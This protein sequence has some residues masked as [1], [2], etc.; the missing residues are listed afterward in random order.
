MLADWN[1]VTNMCMLLSVGM[2][3]SVLRSVSRKV[4]CTRTHMRSTPSVVRETVTSWHQKGD[5]R[6]RWHRCVIRK[7]G[8]HIDHP[9]GADDYVWS[10]LKGEVKKALR[11]FFPTFSSIVIP[12]IPGNSLAV[13]T[14]SIPSTNKVDYCAFEVK[15]S[16]EKDQVGPH[17]LV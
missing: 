8:G 17:R 2:A 6:R 14:K 4:W 13:G 15:H 9:V 12:T 7:S 10:M 3:C 5:I 16:I 1:D 11:R